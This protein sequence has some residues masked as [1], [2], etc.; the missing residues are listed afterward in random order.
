M[1]RETQFYQKL[2][3]NPDFSSLR[4][5]HSYFSNESMYDFEHV[6]YDLQ[7]ISLIKTKISNH[8]LSFLCHAR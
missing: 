2:L 8:L 6:M 4:S 1:V 7:Y 3:H 5:L